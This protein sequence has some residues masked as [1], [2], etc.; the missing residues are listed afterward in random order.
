MILRVM[1][2]KTL[3]VIEIENVSQVVVMMATGEPAACAHETNG[4]AIIA[5]HAG[6]ADFSKTLTSLGV[7]P[8]VVKTL[9]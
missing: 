4:G 3:Q 5:T 7:K 2:G 8:P 6:E 1:S 9:R